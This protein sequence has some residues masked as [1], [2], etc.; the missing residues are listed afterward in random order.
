[1]R[2]ALTLENV[3]LA[4]ESRSRVT[5]P[6]PQRGACLER[7]AALSASQL[8]TPRPASCAPGRVQFQMKWPLFVRRCSRRADGTSRSG[9]LRRARPR[10]FANRRAR[11]SSGRRAAAMIKIKDPDEG[12]GVVATHEDENQHE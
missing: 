5:A 12:P 4:G 1:M 6:G 10:H 7:A 11:R 8:R 9:A 2:S 3:N